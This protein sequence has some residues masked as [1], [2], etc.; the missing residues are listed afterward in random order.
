MFVCFLRASQLTSG[1]HS[2]TLMGHITLLAAAAPYDFNLT[3]PQ[4]G[5]RFVRHSESGRATLTQL[6]NEAQ[7][8]YRTAEVN[9]YAVQ[10]RV[11]SYIETIR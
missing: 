2:I 3:R 8:A 5:F 4:G 7:M 9:M 10:S 1:M 6:G 11:R